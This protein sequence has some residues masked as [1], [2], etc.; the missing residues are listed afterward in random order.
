MPLPGMR[1]TANRLA[2]SLPGL[3]GPAWYAP[4]MYPLLGCGVNSYCLQGILQ[5]DAAK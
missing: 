4:W 2:G 1:K 5:T 3:C